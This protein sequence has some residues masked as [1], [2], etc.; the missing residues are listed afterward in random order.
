M[1]TLT[2]P[3]VI[4]EL[5][6]DVRINLP[7]PELM[8]LRAANRP[9]P[10]SVVRTGNIDTG[11][12]I[13]GVSAA[14]LRQLALA[15]VRNSN[16]Q[17]IGGSTAVNL[18]HVSLSVCDAVQPPSSWF[19]HPDLLVMELPPGTPVDVLI[20]MDVLIQCRLTVDGPAGVFTLDF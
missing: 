19:T 6:V 18:Y 17:G 8:A 11:S 7:A 16:T 1:A 12:N 3:I 2:F 9:T 20:G 14:V 10:T 4:N 13:T 15:P 5:C